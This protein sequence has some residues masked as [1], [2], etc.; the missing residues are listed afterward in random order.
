MAQ[1]SAASGWLTWNKV[2]VIVLLTMIAGIVLG[3]FIMGRVG[4][5]VPPLFPYTIHFYLLLWLPVL[6][7]GILLRP[8]GGSRSALLLLI[9]GG[10][11]IGGFGLILFGPTFNYTAGACQLAPLPDQ[12]VRYEC[13]SAPDYYN[14]Q[15][16]YVLVGNPGS[17][18][19]RLQG[20]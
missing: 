16:P 15:V 12:P 6:I 13:L 19:V 2:V 17:L 1:N 11:L 4:W 8:I 10:T 3:A 7:V 9:V 5:F 18:F 20:G 14:T